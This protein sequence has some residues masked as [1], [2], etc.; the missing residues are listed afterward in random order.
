MFTGLI[1]QIARVQSISETDC[2]I[3]LAILCLGWDIPVQHGE[4]ICTA[5]CCL[6]VVNH[7]KECNKTTIFF[8]VV[9][10]SLACTN[11]GN[12]EVGD[13]VNLER[14]LRADSLLGGHFVQGHIDG[15]EE[16]LDVSDEGEGAL[17]IR[18]SKNAIDEDTVVHKGSI[19]IDGVSL[20]IAAES[21]DWFE[22]A[23][24]P[25]TVRDTTLGKLSVGDKVHIET[26]ILAR[27]VVQV[28]RKMQ[29]SK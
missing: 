12:L 26:D 3:Q 14:S 9:H 1:Q 10:E 17:R 4:S 21:S 29:K 23:L 19:T 22:V 13:E 11:L 15:I 2:G 16:V 20:T 28:V 7:S 6:T 8:D 27:T 24:V 5:G 18:C 25:T